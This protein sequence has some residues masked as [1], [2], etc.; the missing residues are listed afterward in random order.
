[1][2][3]CDNEFQERLIKS[4]KTEHSIIDDAFTISAYLLYKKYKKSL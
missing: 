2:E 3:L 1:M 4:Y